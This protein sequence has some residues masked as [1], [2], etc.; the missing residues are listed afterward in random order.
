MHDF[1]FF[2]YDPSLIK[3]MTVAQIALAPAA[4]RVGLEV[5]VVGN[6]AGE[7]ISI[8]SGTLAGMLKVPPS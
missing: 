2:Q 6:D 5:R 4:A 1:G 7:K 3:F 8:L